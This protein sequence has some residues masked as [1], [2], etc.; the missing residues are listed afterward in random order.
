MR[1]LGREWRCALSAQAHIEKVEGGGR[2]LIA[3]SDLPDSSTAFVLMQ[4][5]AG[6]ERVETRQVMLFGLAW[7]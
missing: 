4:D 7:M 3:W 1:S 6:R 5:S 2:G